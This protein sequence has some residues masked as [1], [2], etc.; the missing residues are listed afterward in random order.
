MNRLSGWMLL[1]LSAASGLLAFLL[2]G[3]GRND[4]VTSLALLIAAAMP[5]FLAVNGSRLIPSGTTVRSIAPVTSLAVTIFILV[6]YP[7]LPGGKHPGAAPARPERVAAPGRNA[8]DEESGVVV[9]DA[10]DNGH[11]IVDADIEGTTVSAM[12]DTGASMVALTYEDAEEIGI[13]VDSLSFSAAVRTAN[14]ITRVAPVV[15]GEVGIE[16][17]YLRDVRAVVMP[18]GAMETSLIGMTFLSRLS[19]YSVENGQL[20]LER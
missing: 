11:F 7:P 19:S 1:A 2:A 9:I 13:D 8:G 3:G 15:L 18:E 14:G 6:V 12:I 4:M 10:S 16:D 17:I 5:F 20:V